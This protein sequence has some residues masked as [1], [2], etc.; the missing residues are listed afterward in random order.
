MLTPFSHPAVTYQPE[1]QQ[2]KNFSSYVPMSSTLHHLSL[3]M[4]LTAV[5]KSLR[6]CFSLRK[7]RVLC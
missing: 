7:R 6:G 5:F 2:I 1:R 3:F 4:K